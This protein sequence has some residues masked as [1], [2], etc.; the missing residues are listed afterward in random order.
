MHPNAM[1]RFPPQPSNLHVFA[2]EIWNYVYEPC[3]CVYTYKSAS[4]VWLHQRQTSSLFL[5]KLSIALLR[6]ADGGVRH[7]TH[8]K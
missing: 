6:K 2:P 8:S 1:L 3:V 4:L 5:P 7:Y